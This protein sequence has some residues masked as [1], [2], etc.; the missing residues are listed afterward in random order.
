MHKDLGVCIVRD[1]GFK[2]ILD[3]IEASRNLAE[4]V[5]FKIK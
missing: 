2:Q 1:K 3:S 4:F 5:D